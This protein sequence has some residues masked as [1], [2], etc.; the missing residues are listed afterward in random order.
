MRL[1]AKIIEEMFLFSGY[2]P[3]ILPGADCPTALISQ[4]MDSGQ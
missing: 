1:A 2:D 4:S 3:T